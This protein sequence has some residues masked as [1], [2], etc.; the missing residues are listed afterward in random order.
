MPILSIIGRIRDAILVTI[1]QLRRLRVNAQQCSDC[2]PTLRRGVL[3]VDVGCNVSVVS[4]LSTVGSMR[5][6][7]G[8]TIGTDIGTGIGNSVQC[9]C[10]RC[11]CCQKV[12]E[13][14]G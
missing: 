10:R 11:A 5:T 4:V 7:T 13:I 1:V 3:R 2:E 12:K 14:V 6:R 8:M 9:R